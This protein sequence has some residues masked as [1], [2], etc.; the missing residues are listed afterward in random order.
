MGKREIQM[1]TKHMKDV[2]QYSQGVPAVANQ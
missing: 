1:A 2:Q